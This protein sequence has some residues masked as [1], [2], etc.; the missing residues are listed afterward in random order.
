MLKDLSAKGWVLVGTIVLLGGTFMAASAAT[1]HDVGVP[2]HGHDFENTRTILITPSGGT[3]PSSMNLTFNKLLP[4]AEQTVTVNYQ[5][6]GTSREDVYVVFP[7]ATAL[8]ALNNLGQYGAVH[9]SSAGAGSLGDV[10]DTTNLSDKLTTCGTFSPSGCWP[11]LAQYAVAR[12]IEPMTK[13]SFSFSFEFAS[14]YSKQAPAGTTA[15][16]NPFPV[17]GQTHVVASDGSGAGLPYEIVATQPG[18]TP[19]QKGN[20]TQIKPFGDSVRVASSGPSFNDQLEVIGASETVN[21][22]VTSPNAHLNVTSGGAVSTVG[23]PLAVGVYTASGTESDAFGDTGTWTYSL[24]VSKSS[25]V[26]GGPHDR[27]VK[28]SGWGGFNDQLSVDG[29]SGSPSFTKTGGDDHFLV[30]SDGRITP[31]GAP[32]KSGTYTIAGSCRDRYGDDGTWS[33]SVTVLH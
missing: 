29:S 9:L 10:F 27:K 13:G 20:I 32:P 18:I 3:G 14:A 28:S 8:S 22:V 7:N 23:G 1:N 2:T 5:N 30:S 11:L 17:T 25:L 33:F 24:A 6:S 15:L 4:G 12:N 26:C 31:N 21:Y 19:G 16:W